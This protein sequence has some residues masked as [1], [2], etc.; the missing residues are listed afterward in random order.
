MI[1]NCQTLALANP[2]QIIEIILSASL[3]DNFVSIF[4]DNTVPDTVPDNMKQSRNQTR[5]DGVPC[6][7]SANPKTV[8]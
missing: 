4:P 2:R 6:G 8:I 5:N 1:L 7:S 3:F